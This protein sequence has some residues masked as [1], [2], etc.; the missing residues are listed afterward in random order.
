M[1]STRRDIAFQIADRRRGLVALEKRARVVAQR[2]DGDERLIQFVRQTGRHLA[3]HRQLARMHDFL[4]RIAQQL[5][6]A[7]AFDDLLLHPFIGLVSGR[8]L[9][10]GHFQ[11]IIGA[12]Q[13][14]LRL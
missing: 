7:R 13:R 14:V 4:L 8:A 3:E 6:G 11:T 1:L 10:H 12:A 5:L 9:L 2:L